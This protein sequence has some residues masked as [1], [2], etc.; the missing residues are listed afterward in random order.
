[1]HCASCVARNEGALKKVPGVW[2]ASVNFATGMCV[3]EYDETKASEHDLH[4]AIK[5]NG[6]TVQAANHHGGQS[7]EH[8]Q[9]DE[10][11]EAKKKAVW[12]I[13]LTIPVLVLAMA[14]V[15]LPFSIL[16]MPGAE[17]V[18]MILGGIVI[19]GFGSQFHR[20]LIREARAF[21]PGMDTLVS[22]GTLAALGFSLYTIGVGGKDS[23]VE[24]GAVI[25]AL[26]LLGRFLEARSRGEASRAIEKLIK[27][28]AKTAH[29]IDE[30]GKEREIAIEEVKVDD[31]IR[32]RPGEKIPVDGV[33]EDGSASV[34]ES[35]LTGESMPVRKDVGD[36]VYGGTINLDGAI[37]F[38]AKGVG[39]DMVLSKIVQMVNEAQT[40]KA[41]IQKFVDRVAG[42]FVPIVIVIALA[43]LVV[44][45][46]TT[47]NLASSIVPAIAVLVIACPCAM[48][49]ATPTAIMVGTGLGASRGIL[50]KNGESLE[51]AKKIDVVL[52]DKTGTLT[53]GHPAVT[54]VI[55]AQPD[56][57]PDQVLSLAASIE[58]LSS[59]PLAQAVAR[60][61]TEKNLTFLPVIG[62]EQV[63]G[64][65]VKGMIDG[66]TIVVG[67]PSLLSEYHIPIESHSAQIEQLE[68]DAKTVIGV[69]KDGSPVGF[70]GIADRVKEESAG[71]VASLKRQGIDTAM[72][73]GDNE[74]TARA[75]A[76][77]I[78]ITEV[79]ARVLPDAKMDIVK[80]LQSKGKKVAFVGD[81]INDAPALVQA[82]LGIA[83][84]TGTDIAIEAGNIVLMKGNP[85]K[86][87][88]A[89]TL[90]RRTFTAIQ[91]NLF[92]A[93]FYNVA[94]IPLAA[95]GLLN[96]II[97]AGAMAFSSISVVLN[98]LRIK[99]VGMK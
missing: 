30:H 33:I 71:A 10:L 47:G 74:R 59:H 29:R 48:G 37:V 42:V 89:L 38:R 18:E 77:T 55:S 62:F 79:F 75:I 15:T 50:I 96:P 46:L 83:L 14:G 69:A 86:A 82:D 95:F 27:L 11:E 34:D 58:T 72:V 63:A 8:R 57:T 22:M 90:S 81:G 5:K 78:G 28:G 32:V 68:S 17:L 85:L 91:Q 40:V 60:A 19:L 88:E 49:L 61:A 26:I 64:K 2:Q 41:P 52:F 97:A 56:F 36:T 23:Y 3:V 9:H 6:Y 53:E 54:D 94:A 25:T 76:R 12:S 99:R 31:R 4:A 20:G 66:S 7:Y 51:R 45:Y 93:F 67:S 65:G 92:W 35:L 39:A 84:G 43:T 1:M 21:A 73:S 16:G 13:V 80:N 24:T 87:V 98:S 70:F 44:W